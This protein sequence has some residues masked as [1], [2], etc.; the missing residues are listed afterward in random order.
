LGRVLEREEAGKM[1][2]R[3]ADCGA[4]GEGQVRS[5]CTCGVTLKTGK[6]VRF[7]CVPNTAKSD[8]N[9]AEIVAAFAPS[10]AD[11]P[12]HRPFQQVDLELPCE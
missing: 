4:Q 2:Y 11:R 3:C 8:A 9:S 5:I 12:R 6:P 10:E 7:Q 1:R